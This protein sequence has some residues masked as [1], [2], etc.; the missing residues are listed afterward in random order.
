MVE[1]V[2]QKK[3]PDTIVYGRGATAWKTD[4]AR[5]KIWSSPQRYEWVQY[6]DAVRNCYQV[7]GDWKQVPYR[8]YL[9][10]TSSFAERWLR[11]N[12]PNIPRQRFDWLVYGGCERA[13]ERKMMA[14]LTEALLQSG[15]TVGYLV[16]FGTEEHQ[17]IASL[18][19]KYSAQLTLIDLYAGIHGQQRRLSACAAPRAWQHF[20]QINELLDGDLR[21]PPTTFSFFL[22]GMAK[23]LLWERI[24]PYMEYDNLIVR[25]HFGSIDSVIALEGLLKGKHVVT[26][27]H[28]VIS[29]MGFFPILADTVVTFGKASAEFMQRI[30][31]QFGQQTGTLPFARRFVPAG[32]LFDE[33][34]DVGDTF[35]HRSLLV[36][37][38]DNPAARRFYGLD[39]ALAGL[40]EIVARCAR[41]IEGITVIYRLHPSAKRV[42]EWVQAIQQECG[43]VQVSQGVP[44]LEDLKRSTVALG[45]F[46]GA[47]TIAA[48]CGVPTFFLWEEG[49]FY[50][51]DLGCYEE[52]FVERSEA[53]R[54]IT[55]VIDSWQDYILW[56]AKGRN[57]SGQY[58]Y[59][60]SAYSFA[61]PLA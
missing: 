25:N 30:D 42:P 23:R 60:R 29:S 5:L 18:Q 56:Q 51:P 9:Q 61:S 2:V 28:G 33:I 44:L 38:Q 45:L 3:L 24:S 14:R 21:I 39:D 49:W 50:T 26:L 20:A 54:T 53:M 6:L 22:G 34:E 37:D 52:M 19:Q 15:A 48:A 55:A 4:E 13:T 36:I 47:L 10:M 1:T 32:S 43:S 40:H 12:K 31:A 35:H 7:E 57:S 17:Q 11:E 41:E 16:R 59:E 27:Q 46:S 58:Y 8:Y